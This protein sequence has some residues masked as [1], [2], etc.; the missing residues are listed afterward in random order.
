[1]N[2]LT[3]LLDLD[4][5]KRVP[6][7]GEIKKEVIICDHTIVEKYDELSQRLSTEIEVADCTG[8]EWYRMKGVWDTGSMIS[9][10]S[11]E[12][13]AKMKLQPVDVGIC[14]GITGTEE[15]PYYFTDVRLSSDIV[16]RNI[17][18]GGATLRNHDVDFLIGLDI[19]SRGQF[20]VRNDNGKTVVKFEY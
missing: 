6:K 20:S 3:G 18:V 19:I 9:V 11:K 13:A 4:E 5:C 2:I 14:V 1:M 8:N 12:K 17:R 7:M 16:I 15:M 10:I